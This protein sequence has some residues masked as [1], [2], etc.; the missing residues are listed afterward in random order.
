MNPLFT[1]LVFIAFPIQ[2]TDKP[3]VLSGSLTN[4][5]PDPVLAGKQDN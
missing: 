4:N 5:H 1:L 2:A 3:G